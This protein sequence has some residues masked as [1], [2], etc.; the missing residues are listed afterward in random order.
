MRI[1]ILVFSVNARRVFEDGNHSLVSYG[2]RVDPFG[3]NLRDP[4]ESRNPAELGGF[5][6]A[7]RVRRFVALGNP[8]RTAATGRPIAI[9]FLG[10]GH[11]GLGICLVF[12]WIRFSARW[13][14]KLT[15]LDLFV[16]TIEGFLKALI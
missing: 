1:D 4:R 13:S 3:K 15:R 16:R 5:H 12:K 9:D 8:P 6:R 10:S 7:G 2:F 14:A 11:A